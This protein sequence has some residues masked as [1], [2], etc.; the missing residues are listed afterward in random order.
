M[1]IKKK[2][3]SLLSLLLAGVMVTGMIPAGLM[4]VSAAPTEDN[5]PEANVDVSDYTDI[6]MDFNY[7]YTDPKIVL[8]NNKNLQFKEIDDKDSGT[9]KW[10]HATSYGP[11]GG[12]F[13]GLLQSTNPDDKYV[14]VA[15]D[16]K[17]TCGHTDYETIVIKSDKVVDLNGKTIRLFDKRNKVDNTDDWSE[18]Y[19]Q[20]NNSIDFQTVM[21]SIENGAT[22]TIIDSSAQQTG[23]IYINAYMINPYKH[24]IKRYTTRDIFNVPDGNLVIYGGT[25][26]AGRSKAQSDDDLFSKIETVVGDAVALAT[27]IAGYA[28]G[29]N[30]ATGAYE[31]AVFNANQAL[32]AIKKAGN[33]DGDAD[34]KTQDAAQTKKKDG[35]DAKPE[36]KKETPDG[37]DSSDAARNKTVAEKQG[38]KDKSK[39]NESNKNG[40]A[41]YDGNS[42]IAAAENA[43]TDAATNKDKIG[44]MVSSAF[45]LAK[46]IKA[47]FETN[48]NS[49]VVQSFLG[50]V[51]NVGNGG[52][53]VSYGGKYIGY[54]MTPNIRN[55]VV[56]ATQKSKV[57]I[58][59]GLF[60]GRCG[61]NIFNIVKYNNSLQTVTQYVEGT[62]GQVTEHTAKMRTDET[63]GLE[64]LSM[65]NKT[66]AQG[67]VVYENGKPVKVPVSTENIRVRGGT[68][69]CYYEG[70]MV[71]LNKDSKEGANDHN[72]DQMTV[73]PGSSGGVNLGV[74][75]YNED[76]IK[77]GRIQLVDSY[78]DGA[79]VL[80]DDNKDAGDKSIFHY[81]LFC[82]DEELRNNR[83]LSVYPNEPGS[84]S[85]YS[86]SLQTRYGG[87]DTAS[88]DDVS[89]FWSDSDENDRGVFS[90]DEKFFTYPINDPKYSE[91]YYVIPYLTNTD[92][93]GQ[94]LDASEVWYY[95]T[96]VDTRGR[97]IESIIDGGSYA[98]GAVNSNGN[99]VYYTY[100]QKNL[101]DKD[102]K[103]VEKKFVS[104]STEYSSYTYNY[105]NNIKWIT[106][107]VYRVDPLTRQ[108][109]TNVYGVD[110]PVVTVRYGAESDKALK[111]RLPL[112]ELGIDYK[113]GEMYR[114]VMNVD[115]YMSIDF[116]DITLDTA[117]CQSSIVFM[118][119]DTDEYKIED[120]Q[121][122]EDYTPVQWINEP[123]AGSTASVQIVNGQAGLIDYQKRKIFD[124]YYQWYEVN[125]NGD[126]ILIAGTDNIY[127]TKTDT[128]TADL[129][130]LR[131]HTFTKML[132]GIDGYKYVNTVNPNDPNVNTYEENGLPADTKKW[133]T[134]MLH[135]YTE[136]DTLNSTL[137][138]NTN[139]SL[140]P[141]N[142]KTMATGTDSCYIPESC[143]GKTIYCKVTAVNNFWLRNF[144]HVQVF[145][146]HKVT[147]PYVTKPLSATISA[148][149]SGSYATYENPVTIKLTEIKNLD[150]DEKVTEVNFYT[151]GGGHTVEFENLSVTNAS[152][153][154]S[155][156]YPKDFYNSTPA[157][158]RA[159]EDMVF[160]AD[161][162]TNKGRYFRTDKQMVDFEVE[163][164]DISI[165]YAKSYFYEGIFHNVSDMMSYYLD[166]FKLK[167][168]PANASTGYSMAEG[169]SFTSSDPEVATLDS[170]GKLV[171][172]TKEGRTT[173][174][175]NK[176]DGTK[177]TLVFAN[178]IQNVSAYGINAPV[179]G[180][181]FDLDAEVPDGANYTV[182]EVYWTEGSYGDRLPANAVA[183]KYRSYTAHVVFQEKSGH[184][185]NTDDYKYWVNGSYEHFVELP[186]NL[187][188]TL[189]DGTTDTVS[190][191]LYGDDNNVW[192]GDRQNTIEARYS[193]PAYVEDGSDLIDTVIINYP[194]DVNEGDSVT[195]WKNQVEV[196][197]DA[198]D[199]LEVTVYPGYSER[200]N[201]IWNAYGYGSNKP[202]V[203][204]NGG[205]SG[206]DVQLSLPSDLSVRFPE[207]K[208]DMT[209]IINGEVTDDLEILSA[210]TKYIS[211]AQYDRLHVH[212]T[213][214]VHFNPP[215]V[216]NAD[217][218]VMAVGQTINLNDL[219]NSQD[220][221]LEFMMLEGTSEYYDYSKETNNLVAKKATP[222]NGSNL[223]GYVS[224][225]FDGK[226]NTRIYT[227]TIRINIYETEEDMPD[228]DTCK[229]TFNVL[230]PDGTS[231]Y[232]VNRYC[233]CEQA[234]DNYYYY[235]YFSIPELDGTII[236]SI[237]CSEGPSVSYSSGWNSLYTSQI[238]G[239]RTYTVHTAS[240]KD[241]NISAG[242]DRVFAWFDGSPDGIYISIDNQHFY[243]GGYIDG[244]D[245]DTEY[246]LYYRQ[247]VDGMVYNKQF[248]TAS[249]DY[250]VMVGYTPVTDLNTGNLERDGWQYDPS[251]KIL[252]LKNLNLE[253]KGTAVSI[254]KFVG[255]Y[256]AT[257]DGVILSH[258]DLTINLIGEN[259][260]KT[261][262][263]KGMGN[264]VIF[265]EHDLTLT[266]NGNLNIS[267]YNES[268]IT[269]RGLF[270]DNGDIYLK[271]TG[272]VT[273]NKIANGI[274]LPTNSTI[275]YYNGEYKYKPLYMT[276]YGNPFYNGGLC[277]S[278]LN[279]DISNKTHNIQVYTGEAG[280][281]ETLVT[282]E[283]AVKTIK[284]N[285]RFTHITPVH[286]CIKKVQGAEYFVE[287]NCEDGA[288]YYK[289]CS[290]GYTDKQSTF[291][292]AGSDHTYTYYTAKEPTCTEEGWNSYR[293]C[294]KCGD[295]NFEAIPATGHQF[296]HHDAVEPICTYS[297]HDA[298]D[299][300][301]VCGLSTKVVIPAT[302]H[303]LIH[304][305]A[306]APSCTQVGW[307]AYDTCEN[308]DYTTYH[309]IPATGHNIVH[310]DGKA[311]TATESGW[312]PYDECTNC[313]YS[314]YTVIPAKAPLTNNSTVSAETVVKGTAVTLTAKAQ[315]GKAPYYYALMYKKSTAS[316]WTKIGEK[317]GTAS[318]GIFTPGAAVKYDIMINVKD[319]SGTIVS[320]SFTL[321]VTEE[322]PLVNNSSL[323][324]EKV[325]PNTKVTVIGSAQGG[326]APYSYEFYYKK[327]KNT[328]WVTVKAAN[329]TE[330]TADVTPTAATPYDIK[331]VVTDSKGKTSEK[332]LTLTVENVSPL[333]NTSTLSAETVEKGKAVKVN[334]SAAGGTAPYTYEFYY[335]KSKNTDWTTVKA[336]NRTETT[337]DIIPTAETDYDVKVV[338]TDS[339]GT[340]SEKLLKFKATSQVVVPLA[341]KSV[342]SAAQVTKGS[343]VT[344]TAK[345]EG[346]TAPYYYAL[347]YKKST[348]STWT[349]I[350]EKYGTASTG[351]F[352]PSAAVDYDIM[353]NVK[354]SSGKI[355][356]KTYKLK[357]TE[358]V[359]ELTNKSYISAAEVKKGTKVTLTA[360]AEGGTAPYYYALMYKKTTANTWTKIG[361]KYGTVSTGSFKPG[362]ATTYDIMINVKDSTGK[363]KSKAFTLTV[364]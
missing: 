245:S 64:V 140:S 152:S 163:A 38:D 49:I 86:F 194:T 271:S 354:D 276:G 357:V 146:S 130:G 216:F 80:M 61:A 363:I 345:A 132:P 360:V 55:A 313:D 278:S 52:T 201:D 210:S 353:I 226:G 249:T 90:S 223:Y 227:R 156:T 144:D 322:M 232:T 321:N 13:R 275:Y 327:S 174:T 247:G 179:V 173:F 122:V 320:K 199:L 15:N 332:L 184:E 79:L 233:D 207:K 181:K 103:N 39:K 35:S 236:R 116:T 113:A 251:N 308:C 12:D 318:T 50:T 56:E 203:F 29:I 97:K 297:G 213:Q 1:K 298:Y 218:I 300:C 120:K 341:N 5:L 212:E 71:G 68:F 87:Q 46:S 339:K 310:H 76:L 155:V 282:D 259:N 202:D 154:K 205:Y 182:K 40:S 237:D 72:S 28:T 250:G 171:V 6:D 316:T 57:Y 279:F 115:E 228:V 59:D 99:T 125:P 150:P 121:K 293:I 186:Y 265:A 119:Y 295:T 93:F 66:D 43:I 358:G 161:I 230:N 136:S 337:A 88:Y 10:K 160:Y 58:Y 70:I 31:D 329:R 153:V 75:S 326:I 187:T 364:K 189:N 255:S 285:A 349:K 134:E 317:Y 325:T 352:K 257:Y 20:S 63:N 196:L 270:C 165:D 169:G 281:D 16:L 167:V 280:F 148:T 105:R 254:E 235:K 22:L 225:D 206:I 85:T 33:A 273:F 129:N 11:K 53:F 335:K 272:K 77:D 324:A 191:T 362:S 266:G 30:A 48:E 253:A 176:P 139:Y 78:G 221:N 263:G 123:K 343:K 296:V 185:F 67:N 135:A 289:S 73:F 214:D 309:E 94:N 108:N 159:R 51:V 244:L 215:P 290:C 138:K 118:C 229:L 195:Y 268:S 311:A 306:Q 92:V 342:I 304:H 242:T 164:K 303:T 3:R 238:R 334:A 102:W 91:K 149:H 274:S 200:Y 224:Y 9:I 34:A 178:P 83:Y 260:I 180:E 294:T 128:F 111:C 96:P 27:D 211:V 246:T 170:T 284:T 45:S 124:V 208:S 19:Y 312:E 37:K 98:F 107:K 220:E 183:E 302:G 197:T 168:T 330:T 95:N 151:N 47:C 7:P 89:Q 147:V 336:A 344:L 175:V 44:A 319:S 112:N 346:G 158:G 126:D 145:Y 361:E 142:N 217:N 286:T 292:V 141:S 188:V 109:I 350:G 127:T 248:R 262:G 137:T 192:K 277:D 204:I 288:T 21:F 42:K 231:A 328:D 17:T 4:T 162:Y 338:A 239:N 351:S 348:A 283:E 117:S 25:Y 14:V 177:E 347:M 24:R 131:N 2:S 222:E 74:E 340:T 315:G 264:T 32:E 84:N 69:R 36:E 243:A 252:T 314:T 323:S 54:G 172:G 18:E 157:Y 209:F 65:V 331:V 333:N 241:I 193:F 301:T 143:E 41:Q 287:G 8:N 359:K 256:M 258:D 269:S 82:T 106:Y 60:E 114:V 305:E 104:G 190:G 261:L 26:Q 100:W 23:N 356:S 355:V 267:G 133:T 110:Q 219:L 234:S 299:E 81:R 240:A 307:D 291:T 166:G 101:S 62:D 198:G